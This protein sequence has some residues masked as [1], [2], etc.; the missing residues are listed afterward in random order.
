MQVTKPRLRHRAGSDQGKL[1]RTLQT[2]RCDNAIAL[3]ARLITCRIAIRHTVVAAAAD[4]TASGSWTKYPT[5]GGWL[6]E[7]APGL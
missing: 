4:R 3:F 6:G 1:A 5:V 7:G 2:D